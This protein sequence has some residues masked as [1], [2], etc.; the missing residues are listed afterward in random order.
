MTKLPKI[1]KLDICI[2][3]G[4]C[5]DGF[6]AAWA[7]WKRFGD[8]V[9]YLPGDY[10]KKGTQESKDY[11]LEKVVGKD[12][13]VF[14]FSFPREITEELAA[15]AKSFVVIDHH[16][17]A[18]AELGDLPYC[19]FD[20]EHSGAHLAWQA[21]HAGVPPMLISYIEDQDLF[22]FKLKNSEAISIFINSTPFEF[23]LFEE[24]AKALVFNTFDVVR[25]GVA[26]IDFR[27]S[28]VDEIVDEIEEWEVNG[29]KF[30]AVNCPHV[31][32]T[33]VCEELRKDVPFAGAYSIYQ[34]KVTWSLR[35]LEFD[36]S[37]IAKLFKGGGGHPQAAGFTVPL[38][39]V[40]F[41]QRKLLV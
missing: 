3:H 16:K 10:K 35:S 5:T 20:M 28:L 30:L 38:E 11:W 12:V 21:C 7:V 9:E 22:R 33:N 6:G 18:Q 36:V 41:I 4:K 13:A 32:R 27:E 17:T 14:D 31:L 39:K 26:M 15:A 23:G 25:A 1:D 19:Y 24:V 2:Y 37:K 29:H 40:D 8:S 34:G